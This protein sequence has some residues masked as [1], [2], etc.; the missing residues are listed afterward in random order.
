MRIIDE[1][2][3]EYYDNEMNFHKKINFEAKL[4]SQKLFNEYAEKALFNYDL[5][6]KSIM[7]S[8]IKSLIRR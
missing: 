5:I 3:S 7:M 2:L 6:S 4:A 8:K 1:N